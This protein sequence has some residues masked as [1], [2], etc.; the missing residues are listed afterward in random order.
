MKLTSPRTFLPG[1]G[2]R[3]YHTTGLM[4]TLS[5][6]PSHSIVSSSSVSTP[7]NKYTRPP[8]SGVNSFNHPTFT[9]K[10]FASMKALVYQSQGKV[11][12]EDRP[13]P[14]I[15]SSTDAIVKLKHTTICGTDLHIIKGDVPTATPGRILGHEGV[16]TVVEVGTSVTSVKPGDTV[17]I[18]CITACGGCSY[19][20][21]EMSS[22]CTSGGW[23][24]GHTIDGTQAEYVRIPHAASS[25]YKLPSTVSLSDAV[26]LSDAMPTGLECGTLN[27]KVK[28]GSSVVVIGAGAVGMSVMMTSMLYSP[29]LLVVVD[30]DD[31]RL[32]MARSF[33]AH[34]TVNGKNQTEA[35]EKLMKLTE[36]QGFDAVIEAVGVP[37]TFQ[38]CQEL[39]APGGVIANV[40]VHGKKVDLHLEK[41]WDRNICITTRLVDAVTT[42]MLL[43]LFKAG[44]LDLSKLSTHLELIDILVSRTEF[45]F[46]ECEKAYNVFGAAAQHN[47]MKV[48]IN[49]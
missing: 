14:T 38:L 31:T 36:G 49:M 18:S 25:L 40:G 10:R 2:M 23:I 5:S 3:K 11:A 43:K 41:L 30:L 22:H 9:T 1:T 37:G 24:L 47:A 27:G 26:M 28:P 15:Q 4:R 46:G 48:L 45:S 39:V 16:G 20:R 8:V 17:L 33:G 21:R 13:C 34:Q 35:V 32:A 44:K 12:L 42:P 6:R 7:G 19:C 29:A